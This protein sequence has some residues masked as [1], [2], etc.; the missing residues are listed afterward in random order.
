MHGAVTAASRGASVTGRFNPGALDGRNGTGFYDAYGAS[1]AT[2]FN[3][4][5]PRDGDKDGCFYFRDKMIPERV[6]KY[7]IQ[8]MYMAEKATVL[9]SEQLLI[10]VVANKPVKLVPL[11]NPATPTVS[12][13]KAEETRTLVKNLWLKTVDEHS[14]LAGVTL[15]GTIIAE[16]TYPSET[17]EEMP[18]FQSNAGTMEFPFENGSAVIPVGILLLLDK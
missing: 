16:I 13:V 6:E 9:Y 3:C 4:N 2:V 1:K 8:F 5:K 17:E 14:N 12:N 7:C 10:D 11:P 15:N 18:H